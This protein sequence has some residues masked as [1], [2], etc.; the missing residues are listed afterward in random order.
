MME[1]LGINTGYLVM[2]CGLFLILGIVVIG[3]LG[4]VIQRW[5]RRR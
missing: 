4:T 2:Q 1:E 3:L 5:F